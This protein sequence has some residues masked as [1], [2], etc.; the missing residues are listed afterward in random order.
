MASGVR[1]QLTDNPQ[2]S[3]LH[4]H[5]GCRLHATVWWVRDN[6]APRHATCISDAIQSTG[7]L[8][9]VQ[10]QIAG[11]R[12]APSACQEG[13]KL[14]FVQHI[15]FAGVSC[16]AWHA[17]GREWQGNVRQRLSVASLKPVSFVE[18]CRRMVQELERMRVAA[19]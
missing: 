1:D 6:E 18:E 2:M 8:A 19:A 15:C 13:I 10:L 4:L 7:F 17:C 16:I 3:V 9:T 11:P 14:P 12:S 5:Q